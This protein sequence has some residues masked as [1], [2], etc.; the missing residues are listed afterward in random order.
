MPEYYR[1]EPYPGELSHFER[2]L[3]G[4]IANLGEREIR[5]SGYVVDTLEASLWCFLRGSDFTETVLHAVNLGGDT[6][7]TGAV[8]GGIAGLYYGFSA[9]PDEWVDH[10]ARQE[11]IVILGKKLARSISS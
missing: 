1:D 8:A 7:T 11:D 9:I 4:D 5:T 3:G 10:V 2:V 6:D